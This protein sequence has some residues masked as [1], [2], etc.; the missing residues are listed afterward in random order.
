[1]CGAASPYL[2]RMVLT[3]RLYSKKTSP[4]YTCNF[5]PTFHTEKGEKK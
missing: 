4:K 1:M 5:K 2:I 3:L